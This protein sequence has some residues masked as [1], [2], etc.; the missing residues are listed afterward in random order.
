MS[1]NRRN[2]LKFG[3]I[4]VAAAATMAGCNK[5]AKP[6]SVSSSKKFSPN[7][8]VILVEQR[9]EFISCPLSNLWIVDAIDLE[10]LTHDYL[11]AARENNYPNK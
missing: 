1:M 8:D 3:A 11:Q 6:S 9:S 4:S 7:A 2:L 10:F 5:E